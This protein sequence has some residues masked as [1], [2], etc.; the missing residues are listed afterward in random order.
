VSRRRALTI[1]SSVC[2]RHLRKFLRSGLF[3]PSLLMPCM[4]FAAFAGGL[5]AVSKTPRFAYPSY[6]SFVF[7]F[8]LLLGA[9]YVAVFSAAAFIAD[10]EG[11]FMSRMMLAVPQ[12]TAIVAGLVFAGV[13]EATFVLV[14]ISG[15]GLAAGMKVSGSALQL[16]AIAALALLLNIAASLWALGLALRLRS[17]E[18]E[19]LMQLPLF[20]VMFLAPAFVPR[21]LLDGWLKTAAGLNPITPLLE[22][23]RGLLVHESVHVVLAFASAGG[24]IVVFLVW[25]VLGLR[26]A[27]RAA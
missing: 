22:A 1:A 13:A 25:A 15:I 19:P 12:R 6:T 23:G 21:S 20:A 11:R 17:S 16:L 4:F 8:V 14:V 5:S 3:V 26:K 27:E 10:L 2:V 7:V 9:S 24:L 18:A